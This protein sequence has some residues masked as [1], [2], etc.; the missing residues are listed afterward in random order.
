[1]PR[2]S[3]LGPRPAR[4]RREIGFVCTAASLR[5]LGLFDV[6][7]SRRRPIGFVCTTGPEKAGRFHRNSVFNPQ[8]TICNLA[9][10]RLTSSPRLALFVPRSSHRLPTTAF[11]LCLTRRTQRD[12]RPQPKP[13][14]SL[15]RE[16]RQE[17]TTTMT[18]PLR[19][20]RL[21]AKHNSCGS[22]ES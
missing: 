9:A 12:L 14:L 5:Q 4:H 1:M 19:S 16:E 21:G 2:S 6:A 18:L 8:S 13:G 22:N 17:D 3:S 10:S 15:R 11:W 20:W 7:R